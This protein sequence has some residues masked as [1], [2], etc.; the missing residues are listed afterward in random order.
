MADEEI[1]PA[2]ELTPGEEPEV[3]GFGSISTTRSNIKG[4]SNIKSG[5]STGLGPSDFGM[6]PPGSSGD[7]S[8]KRHT[9]EFNQNMG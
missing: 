3:E 2:D 8:I 7:S 1:E 6:K 4:R 5:M 9:I